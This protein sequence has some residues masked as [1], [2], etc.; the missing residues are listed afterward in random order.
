MNPVD[1]LLRDV[2]QALWDTPRAQV[3]IADELHISTKHLSMIRQGHSE[4][5]LALLRDLCRV[6]GVR[7]GDPKPPGPE[8]APG[9]YR[10]NA[11][12]SALTGGFRRRI[13]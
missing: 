6:L 9:V 12:R 1:E 5:S 11:P 2:V 8:V 7:Q 10:L 13:E 4:P 3:V